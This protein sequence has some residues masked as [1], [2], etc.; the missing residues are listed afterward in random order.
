MAQDDHDDRRQAYRCEPSQLMAPVLSIIHNGRRLQAE[1]V[2]DVTLRGA[3][4]EF[5]SAAG[6]AITSGAAIT[7]T[8]MAPG[9]DGCA[10]VA[11][12][13]V[14]SASRGQRHVVAMV[15]VDEPDVADRCDS[16]FFSVFNRRSTQRSDGVTAIS[17][18]LLPGDDQ[19][20][21]PIELKVIN[22]SSGGIGFLVDAA[23]DE[24]IRGRD[25]LDIAVHSDDAGEPRHRTARVLHRA[26]NANAIYYG[27]M[28]AA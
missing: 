15:F 14:F 19:P 4:V 17:A 10:D 16:A 21:E 23:L 9:L 2:I 11:A 3:R 20:A 7:V 24:L 6:A 25:A 27:C 12:R 18:M 22:H 8:L 26:T 13:V 5:A 1:R 28:Y